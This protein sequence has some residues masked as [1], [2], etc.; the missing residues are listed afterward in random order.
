MVSPRGSVIYPA[1]SIKRS[2]YLSIYYCKMPHLN[3]ISHYHYTK[4]KKMHILEHFYDFFFSCYITNWRTSRSGLKYAMQFWAHCWSRQQERSRFNYEASPGS[5]EQEQ[6]LVV[7]YLCY[8]PLV[9]LFRAVK[10]FS[11]LIICLVE[12]KKRTLGVFFEKISTY[13]PL[14]NEVY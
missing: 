3:K 6:L 13:N 8:L 5:T 2:K 11:V 4:I 1:T 10:I 7:C 12:Q 14:I 9:L